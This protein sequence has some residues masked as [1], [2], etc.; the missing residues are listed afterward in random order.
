M[1]EAATIIR[2]VAGTAGR[3]RQEGRWP[4]LPSPVEFAEAASLAALLTALFLAAYI[5]GDALAARRGFALEL[6]L[7]AELAIPL[8][9]VFVMP[10]LSMFALFLLP[11]FQM[12]RGEVRRLAAR[13]ALGICVC[14]VSFVLLPTR[15]GFEPTTVHGVFAP[16]FQA[17]I[18]VDA[19]HNLVP[20]LHV[21]ASTLVAQA[22]IGNAVPPMRAVYRVWLAL[23]LASVVLTHRHHLID[24]VAGLAVVALCLRAIPR[25]N[26][27]ASTERE[28]AR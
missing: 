25:R 23:I 28:P 21:V 11:V 4:A 24:I 14:G 1:S 3:N 15:L 22:L 10:Y 2:A 16:V 9:P 12:D 8:V 6:Y 18:A 19:T 17:I 27:D 13:V 26:R 20:S 5:G 7:E